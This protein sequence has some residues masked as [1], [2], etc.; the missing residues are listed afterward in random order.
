MLELEA[1]QQRILSALRPLGVESVSLPAAAGRYL[2][3]A[4]HSPIDLP[5]FDNSAVDGYAVQAQDLAGAS[6]SH[7][8]PLRCMGQVAAGEIFPRPITGGTCVRVFTGSTLPAG[9]D[10]VVMQEDTRLEPAA[11]ESVRFLDAPKPGEGIRRRGEDVRSGTLLAASGQRVTVGLTAL[12]AAAGLSTLKVARQVTAGV[13]ATGSELQESGQALRPGHIYESNRVALLAL[14]SRAG[15]VARQYPLVPDTLEATRAA[16]QQALAENDLVLS[17]GGASVGELDFLKAAFQA[18]GGQIDFWQVAIKPGKP[19]L[20]G[21][22]G[23]KFLF[24]LP[25]NPVSALVSFILLVRPALDRLQG[26]REVSAPKRL[27]TLGE[28]LSNPANRRHFVRVRIDA[29]GTVWSA[30]AQTSHGLRSLAAADGL[31]EVPAQGAL[32]AGT[33]VRVIGVNPDN[34]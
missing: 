2:A 3:Q 26:A 13:L 32:S 19:F 18:I 29:T 16:L 23:Q 30:G 20:F 14:L 33:L 24:G 9:A 34:C 4:I 7:P 21:R 5:V 31:V 6:A 1:A 11:P 25:G 22:H 17:S 15:V 27:G 12:L 10:A 28:T 8:L